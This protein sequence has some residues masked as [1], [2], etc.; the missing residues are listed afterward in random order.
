MASCEMARGV[1]G[2][3]FHF[4]NHF[5][6]ALRNL[7]RKATLIGFLREADDENEA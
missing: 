5:S 6:R 3:S 1:F 2:R 7:I 4:G